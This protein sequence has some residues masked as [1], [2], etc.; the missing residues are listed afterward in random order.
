[1]VCRIAGQGGI[2]R[3]TNCHDDAFLPQALLKLNV[4]MSGT[5]TALP[6]D[7][8][9][10][11]ALVVLAAWYSCSTFSDIRSSYPNLII[12]R[13]CQF[14]SIRVMMIVMPSQ[15]SCMI[16]HALYAG[17]HSLHTNLRNP[18]D[19]LIESGIYLPQ[20]SGRLAPD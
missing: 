12:H 4:H 14:L 19:S 6:S 5:V 10:A 15:P 7:Q 18:S 17:C 3:L 1:M 9:A 20:T 8:A 11:A 16:Q 13:F 2:S